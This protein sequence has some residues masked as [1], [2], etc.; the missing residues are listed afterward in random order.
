[1]RQFKRPGPPPGAPLREKTAGGF[2]KPAQAPK[3]AL[4]PLEKKGVDDELRINDL[5]INEELIGQPLL[6]RKYTKELASINKKVK[7][8]KNKL[9]LQEAAVYTLLSN[10]GK[11]Y[12]VAEVEA[13]VLQDAEV[14]KLRVELYDAEELAEEFTGIV[15]SFA[16]RM[17]ALQQLSNNQRKEMAG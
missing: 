17:E 9:E 4:Q 13:L 10:S 1:M 11:G 5:H 15:R 8:I 14:Q 6:M 3:Q 7:S 16:Q 12:K 2:D